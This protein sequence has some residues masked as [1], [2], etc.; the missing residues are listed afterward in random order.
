[1]S[2]ISNSQSMQR[3]CLNEGTETLAAGNG[4]TTHNETSE[5]L[6]T[7]FVI[8]NPTLKAATVGALP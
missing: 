3:V 4:L 1:M 8:A 6:A 5:N 2:S 7:T